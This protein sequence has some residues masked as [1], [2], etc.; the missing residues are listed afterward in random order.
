MFITTPEMQGLNAR[1]YST[2]VSPSSDVRLSWSRSVIYK[3]AKQIQL[4]ITCADR[5]GLYESTFLQK[6]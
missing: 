1:R 4:I 6:V 3:I 5:A 2:T